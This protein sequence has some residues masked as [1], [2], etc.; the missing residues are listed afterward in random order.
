MKRRTFIKTSLATVATTAFASSSFANA[1]IPQTDRP[2]R[3]GFIGTGNRGTGVISEMSRNTNMQIIT[4]ADLLQD[5]IDK[6]LPILNKLNAAKNLPAIKKSNI[7]CGINA[8]KELLNNKEVDAVLISTTAYAHPFIFHDAVKA[9]KH[10]YCEKPAAPDVYGA[11]NMLNDAK[12]I[13]DL[14]LVMGFQIRY[15][16]PFKEMVSRIKNGDIGDIVTAQLNYNSSEVPMIPTEGTEDEFRLRNHFHY[17]GLSGGI[18]NDQAIHMI[19]VC[20]W[21]LGTTPSSAIGTGNRRKAMPFGDALTN[22]QVIYT[23]PNDI[24]VSVTAYQMGAE[25]GDVCA[26]FIGTKGWAEA[27]YSGGVFI[28]GEHPWASSNPNGLYDADKNKG[29]SF[30]ESIEKKQ[31]LN[32]IEDGCNSTLSTIMGRE[33]VFSGERIFWDKMLAEK[34]RMDTGIDI[35]KIK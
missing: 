9:H 2:V 20:N 5:K 19:D 22:Y 16:T 14:S 28:K 10:V 27:H 24:N 29:I 33:A 35:T 21:V 32:L 30:I 23:Y 17:L 13:T 12:G 26:R 31:Y 1:P 25:F 34:K 15:A 6:A 3:V 8:Y 11:V 4:V 7:Y 18:L